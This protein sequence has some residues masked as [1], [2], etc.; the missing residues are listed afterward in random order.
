ATPDGAFTTITTR[1]KAAKTPIFRD[2][3]PDVFWATETLIKLLQREA[4]ALAQGETA[5]AG[6]FFDDGGSV[7]IPD[8]GTF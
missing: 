5:G 2:L 4:E 3:A 8:G 7:V 6:A 1:S